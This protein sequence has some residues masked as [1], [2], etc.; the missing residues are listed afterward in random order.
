MY[1]HYIVFREPATYAPISIATVTLL[2]Y[3]R[4]DHTLLIVLP[5]YL[6]IR[7]CQFVQLQPL[8]GRQQRSRLVVYRQV[9]DCSSKSYTYVQRHDSFALLLKGLIFLGN[10]RPVYAICSTIVLRSLCS[11][12]QALLHHPAS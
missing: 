12:R 7:S 6:N 8:K 11:P 9:F 1:D 5:S 10:E 2:V 3:I 4:A